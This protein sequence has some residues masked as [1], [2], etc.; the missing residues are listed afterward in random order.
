[1]CDPVMLLSREEW[2]RMAIDPRHARP[3]LLVFGLGRVDA[4]CLQWARRIA[5]QL[6]VDVVVLH[7]GAF[8]LSG[9]TNVRDAGPE[10]F[11]GWIKQAN[12]II[13]NS[14]HGSCFSILLEKQFC[15]LGARNAVTR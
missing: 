8:A 14:F 2:E 9:V 1:M 4:D 10:E 5:D 15:S 11:L 7:N 13:T 3:Y 12:L 6:G